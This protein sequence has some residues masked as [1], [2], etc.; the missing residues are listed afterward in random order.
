MCVIILFGGPTIP[1]ACGEEVTAGRSALFIVF[2]PLLCLRWLDLLCDALS[3]GPSYSPPRHIVASSHVSAVGQR[4]TTPTTSSS[5]LNTDFQPHSD[6]DFHLSVFPNTDFHP[7][8]HLF[9]EPSPGISSWACN[10]AHP[11]QGTEFLPMAGRDPSPFRVLARRDTDA[12]SGSQGSDP[13]FLCPVTGCGSSYSA[14][15]GLC[16]HLEQNHLQS[17]QGVSRLSSSSISDGPAAIT[18]KVCQQ[19]SSFLSVGTQE[20]VG[21]KGGFWGFFI[22]FLSSCSFTVSKCLPLPPTLSLS[23][24]LPRG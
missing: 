19:P 7:Q 24:L 18:C 11:L 16:T 5:F 17:S 4:T 13:R 20:K 9:M 6:I 21:G 23:S 8:R 14:L 10:V 22:G 12:E 3:A 2:F 15:Q 1:C